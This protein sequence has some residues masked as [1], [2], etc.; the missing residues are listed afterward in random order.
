VGVCIIVVVI[1][2]QD[3]GY[4]HG[5]ACEGDVGREALADASGHEEETHEPLFVS[6][7]NAGCYCSDIGAGADDEQDDEEEGLEVEE[8][9]HTYVRYLGYRRI[10]IQNFTG[11]SPSMADF[12]DN[13]SFLCSSLCGP[14]T[15]DTFACGRF[16]LLPFRSPLLWESHLIFFS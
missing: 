9:G 14:A 12:P 3:E 5:Y 1:S 16:R 8:G 2:V 7:D 4:G 6:V 10:C 15:P 11:L 13:S